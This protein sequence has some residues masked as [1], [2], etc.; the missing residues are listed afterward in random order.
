M[1]QKFKASYDEDGDVLTIY[2]EGS[3]V[4][5]SIE[6]ADDLVIDIDKDKKLVNLEL[7]DAYKFLHTLNE[8]ISRDV[9]VEMEEA[10]LEVKNY[11]N[12]GLSLSFLGI[13]KK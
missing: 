2:K 13:I 8:K 6:V 3:I 10:E 4:K 7:L 9:L 12:Y 1:K 11:R 5:E